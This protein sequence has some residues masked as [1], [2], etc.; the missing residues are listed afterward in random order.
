MS[1]QGDLFGISD[2]TPR[3]LDTRIDED[4]GTSNQVLFLGLFLDPPRYH[5]M[6]R[7]NALTCQKHSFRGPPIPP[8]RLHISLHGFGR[9]SPRRA[10]LISRIAETIHFPPLEITLD[11]ALS[12]QQ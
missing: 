4:G 5:M 3:A 10:T 7:R 9:Y 8:S 12:Y 11:K 1:K 2:S 6:A